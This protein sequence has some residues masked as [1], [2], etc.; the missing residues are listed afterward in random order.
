MYAGS[1]VFIHHTIRSR[2]PRRARGLMRRAK[3]PRR[4][5]VFPRALAPLVVVVRVVVRV[6]AV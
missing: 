3:P 6:V 4:F 2:R 1:R 5:Y